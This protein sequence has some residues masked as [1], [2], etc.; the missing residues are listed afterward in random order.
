MSAS[1][2]AT[3]TPLA[4]I[5]KVGSGSSENEM[6]GRRSILTVQKGGEGVILDKKS[7]GGGG[8]RVVK[9]SLKGG[10]RGSCQKKLVS[11]AV[12]AVVNEDLEF[13]TGGK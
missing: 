13:V 10:K 11:K 6:V 12:Q 3:R 5:Q 2:P 1:P 8:G 4:R 9:L 7:G